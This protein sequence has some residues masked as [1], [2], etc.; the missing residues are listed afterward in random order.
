MKTLK[1]ITT[2]IAAFLI[3]NISQ[4]QEG[5]D[6]SDNIRVLY[7]RVFNG[8]TIPMVTVPEVQVTY[9]K[10]KDQKEEY[11]Y[12]YY[13]KRVKK[14]YPYYQ[15]ANQVVDELE[16]EKNNSN[17]RG[18]N[19]YKKNRKQELMK[20]FEKELRDLKVSEG[21]VLV[22]MINRETG[23]NF[24]DLIKEYNSG[25]KAWT[26]NIVANRYDYDLKEVYDPNKEENR[27]LELAIKQVLDNN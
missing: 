17:K 19:K 16:Y 15:I 18:Y 6:Y 23:I 24:Y 10:F 25:I 7:G 8:D 3:A 26:Y 11:W 2:I 22:K 12:N 13:L 1:N 27:M 21:K 20:E 5:Y 14:V 9:Y 4:A